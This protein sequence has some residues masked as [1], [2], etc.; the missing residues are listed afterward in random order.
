MPTKA[1]LKRQGEQLQGKFA[2][3]I[4]NFKR[5]KLHQNSFKL[6]VKPTICLN[7]LVLSLI[8]YK[9][10]HFFNIFHFCSILN[11]F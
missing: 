11:A 8:L 1:N 2:Y 10:L 4:S 6:L 3:H 7:L 5:T 9:C